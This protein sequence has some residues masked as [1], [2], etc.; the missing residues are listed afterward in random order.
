M[1]TSAEYILD[2]ANERLQAVGLSDP[3]LT[4]ITTAA[5]LGSHIVKSIHGLSLEDLK[6]VYKAGDGDTPKTI[7][8][9]E[10]GGL[11]KGL[12][13]SHF[14][15]DRINE[16]ESGDEKGVVGSWNDHHVDP[17]DGTSSFAEGQRYSTVGIANY[18]D[19]SPFASVICHP[20]E[21]ELVVAQYGK[22]AFLFE[23]RQDQN[24]LSLSLGSGKQ[25]EVSKATSLKG[26]QAYIDALFNAK[27]KGPKFRFMAGLVEMAVDNFGFRMSGSNI[28][29]QLKVAKGS[30]RLTL[31]DAVGGFFDLAAGGLAIIEAG[32]KFTDKDGYPVNESTQV[33]IGSNGPMH[34]DILEL[35]RVCYKG[36]QGFR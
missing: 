18:R 23:L 26:G 7:A 6:I 14:P 35:A 4:V 19:G 13:R 27:T 20:F 30:A 11:I 33:A 21:N 5:I 15:G 29:Q 25:L 24:S 34:D 8:D 28:D 2:E 16:E 12:I 36:Y 1:P 9:T 17:L 10:S 31:T 3:R 22:G 32:G